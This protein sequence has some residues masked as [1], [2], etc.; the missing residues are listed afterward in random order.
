MN[1]R[2]SSPYT[3]WLI[4]VAATLASYLFQLKAIGRHPQQLG[5]AVLLIAFFKVRLIGMR[6]M[7]LHDSTLALRLAFDAWVAI[8]AITLV[9]LFRMA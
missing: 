4:L 8:M 6:Y 3:V 7:E 5:T 1:L 9:I 2:L